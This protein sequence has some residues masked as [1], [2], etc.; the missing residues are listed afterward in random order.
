MN[1]QNKSRFSRIHWKTWNGKSGWRL[2]MATW[3]LIHLEDNFLILPRFSRICWKKW[4]IG[5]KIAYGKFG[6]Y[7]LVAWMLR[8]YLVFLKF[9]DQMENR[10]KAGIWEL[11]VLAACGP[12]SQNSSRFSSIQWKKIWKIGSKIKFGTLG[13]VPLEGRIL[14]IY[15]AFLEFTKNINFF[16]K[17]VIFSI[18]R[19]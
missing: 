5:V 2:D 10:G 4:K 14:E 3:D 11:R 16:L 18:F 13:S 12:N 17:F 6:Y 8:I 9:T 15:P 1:S 7:P 19:F